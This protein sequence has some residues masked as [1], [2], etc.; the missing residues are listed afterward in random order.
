MGIGPGLV[1]FTKS[2]MSNQ[3]AIRVMSGSHHL[4]RPRAP[5]AR[6]LGRGIPGAKK[7]VFP[8]AAHL[9]TIDMSKKFNDVIFGF[10]QK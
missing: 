10:L 7:I 5:D 8:N 2:R 4:W 1:R 9:V 6:R 3:V